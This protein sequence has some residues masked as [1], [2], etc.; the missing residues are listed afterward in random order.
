MRGS[1]SYRASRS[2]RVRR[3]R[4]IDAHE[5]ADQNDLPTTD[6]DVIVEAPATLPIRSESSTTSGKSPKQQTLPFDA[7][8]PFTKVVKKPVVPVEPT[9]AQ[10]ATLNQ[11]SDL[12]EQT[13]PMTWVFTGERMID[14]NQSVLQHR[15][16]PELISEHV[17][18]GWRRLL[19]VVVD[20]SVVEGRIDNLLMSLDW[21][22]LRMQPDVVSINV[23]LS[24]STAGERGLRRFQRRLEMVIESIQKHG[25]IAI[26][27]TPPPVAKSTPRLQALPSYVEVM[28]KTA[29]EFGTPLIDHWTTWKIAIKNLHA[30][31]SSNA[32]NEKRWTSSGIF[33]NANGHLQMALHML[34][35]FET[36]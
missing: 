26:L 29:A 1:S 30:S 23:G 19:D 17:R 16:F 31:K 9:V 20:T 36:N 4:S 28:Q 11:I 21:R 15:T 2:A 18:T 13:S 33:P 6:A 32:A 12:I 10:V 14:D 34:E 35:H 8:R 24:D 3:I 25:S 5:S 27:N 7:P 22:A